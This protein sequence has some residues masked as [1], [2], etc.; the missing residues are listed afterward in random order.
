[1]FST[2]QQEV[3]QVLFL[4]KRLAPNIDAGSNN[5]LI[6]EDLTINLLGSDGEP[7][8]LHRGPKVVMDINRSFSELTLSSSD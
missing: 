7:N 2:E 8:R 1:M 4:V 3:V 6:S 5:L